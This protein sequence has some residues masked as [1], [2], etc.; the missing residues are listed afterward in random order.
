MLL[1]SLV[2]IPLLI[3]FTSM[4]PLIKITP[5]NCLPLQMIFLKSK[6]RTLLFLTAHVK[7]NIEC[8]RRLESSV[9]PLRADKSATGHSYCMH[10]LKMTIYKTII[11][12]YIT[13]YLFLNPIR[14]NYQNYFH[15]S[16]HF[17]YQYIFSIS[18]TPP[19]YSLMERTRL[20]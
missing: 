17:L 8:H 11:S 1:M 4:H 18:L 13:D 16:N 5:P 20:K 2:K 14:K 12:S 15:Q 3:Y 6:S 9:I 10:R 19:L 7:V